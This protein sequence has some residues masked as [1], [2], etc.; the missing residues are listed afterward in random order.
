M[1][2]FRSIYRSL[3]QWFTKLQLLTILGLIIF[4]FFVTDSNIFARFSYDA[5][6]MDLNRQIKYYQEQ[7]VKDKEKLEQ[8]HSSEDDIEKFAREQYLMKKSN[9][10][11]FVIE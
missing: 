2:F 11:I 10:D 1:K 5:K 9:E 3:S 4:A 8:L 6:I 7:A